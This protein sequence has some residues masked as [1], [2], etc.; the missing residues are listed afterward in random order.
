[1]AVPVETLWF[2]CEETSGTSADDASA[3]GNDGTLSA[4][5]FANLTVEGKIGNAF[6]LDATQDEYLTLASAV[7]LGTNW[8]WACW[9]NLVSLGSHRPW[10][11]AAYGGSPA[12]GHMHYSTSST[13][14]L[15]TNT[16]GNSVTFSGMGNLSGGWHH[17]GIAKQ[18]TSVKLYI[19]GA[20]YDEQTLANG[21][22]TLTVNLIGRGFSTTEYYGSMDDFRFCNNGVWEL[23]QFQALYNSGNGTASGMATLFPAG[24]SVY[25]RLQEEIAA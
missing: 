12:V 15:E 4:G 3:S 11:G 1:M 2:K 16:D 14:I 13:I 5:T 9:S 20:L 22:D 21:T 23:A 6:Y 7:T 24:N 10:F 8:S 25:Y 19:D 17:F 18:G